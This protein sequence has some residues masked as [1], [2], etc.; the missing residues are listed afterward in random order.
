M[1]VYEKNTSAYDHAQ[2]EIV[3]SVVD[4]M[5]II[6]ANTKIT[7][8]ITTKGHLTVAGTVIGDINAKGNVI[9]TGTVKGKI[10]CSNLLLE[11]CSIQS[12]ITASESIM[13]KENVSV[14]GRISCCDISVMSFV[15]GDITASGK[16]GLSKDAVVKGNITA[17][18]LGVE[19]GAKIEGMLSIR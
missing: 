8:N 17:S 2:T 5:G 13:I 6:A 10:I 11:N 4:E 18:A 14:Q 1:G 7:G 12:E 9:V 19:A 16:I 15:N 3:S